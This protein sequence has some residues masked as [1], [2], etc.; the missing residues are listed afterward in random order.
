MKETPC[1]VVSVAWWNNGR[2]SSLRW[3]GHVFNFWSCHYEVVTTFMGNCL[4]TGKPS[5][6]IASIKVNSAF[7]PSG[8]AKSSTDLS[9]W[10]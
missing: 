10:R 5:W 1:S 3:R 7:Y 6:Y 2:V 8:V 4:Q 9:S